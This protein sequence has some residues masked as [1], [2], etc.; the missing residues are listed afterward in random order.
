MSE[1]EPA[2]NPPA[3]AALDA[4]HRF[5]G[6]VALAAFT[7][8]GLAL[9]GLHGW[10]AMIYLGAGQEER[11]LQWTLAHAHGTLL[12][13]LH[14]AFAYTLSR[15]GSGR[16]RAIGFASRALTAATILLPGGFLLGGFGASGA[17]PGPGAL[18]VPVGGLA[19]L[20]ALV[21]TAWAARR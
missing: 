6:W 11:R 10:K 18:L 12:G 15:I 19:L 16:E 8:F 4:R 3:K 21:A 2:P 17:D 1:P 14:I 9:D 5:I 7:A 20:S 13:L